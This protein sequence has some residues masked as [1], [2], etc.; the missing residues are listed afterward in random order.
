[1]DIRHAFYTIEL[2]E[3]CRH[4]TAFACELGKWQF[5]FLPQ[6]LKI[7]PAVFQHRIENDLAGLELTCPFIDDVGMA[8]HTWQEHLQQL[9]NCFARLLE[10]GYKLKLEKCLLMQ[11]S[12]PFVGHVCSAA[13][14]SISPDKQDGV[15]KLVA[16]TTYGQ[17]K[18]LLG[19]C[20]FLRQYV[21]HYCDVI[22]PLND[23]G[24]RKNS[25]RSEANI[26]SDWTDVHDRALSLIK[27]MLMSAEVLALPDHRH[28]FILFTDASKYHMSA[29]LMQQFDQHLRPIGYWSK[30]FKGPQLYWA[31]LVKEARA[32]YEAV[33]HYEVLIKGCPINLRC[34]HLPLKEFLATKTKNEMVNR[35]S[36]A[37]QEFQIE[38]THVSSENNLSDCLSR[39]VPAGLY[40]DHEPNNNFSEI[41]AK[42]QFSKSA[43][44]KSTAGALLALPLAPPATAED[45]DL[46]TRV[47]GMDPT[48][49]CIVDRWTP[50]TLEQV[51]NMQKSDRY[52]Q[53]LRICM[54]AGKPEDNGHF[55]ERARSAVQS[56]CV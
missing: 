28:G 30:P 44:S 19:F 6:G 27:D 2:T 52:C 24:K 8:H 47:L 3:D 23:L 4:M 18:S 48:S 32:V 20:S 7:S 17:L 33:Q 38:F 34:D 31:A 37:I 16:P 50:F 1:M 56:S 13:G 21:P 25:L 11:T 22:K 49:T 54:E 55:V 5:R 42:A 43:V 10:C 40:V 46:Q 53:R 39:L 9:D 36:L 29:V 51:A 15:A 45:L 41:P 26:V 12:I 14:I 35:W